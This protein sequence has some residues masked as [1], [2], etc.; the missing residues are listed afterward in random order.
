M[1][2]PETRLLALLPAFAL[3]AG[4]LEYGP[5]RG[6]QAGSRL[7]MLHAVAS[8][9]VVLVWFVADARRRG[10]RASIF[11]KAAMLGATAV[12]LPYYLLR[13]R[14]LAG[15]LRSLALAALVFAGT[16]VAYHVGALFA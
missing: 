9:V 5:A 11:L 13:S 15:G 10:Y 4:C 8:L 12:A 6:P 14:G 1:A 2:R 7:L 3:V 16:M